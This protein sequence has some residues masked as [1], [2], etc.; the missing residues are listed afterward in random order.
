MDLVFCKPADLFIIIA[1]EP[2]SKGAW[3]PEPPR[4]KMPGKSTMECH[5]GKK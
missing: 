3:V 1:A 4:G 5:T 2:K